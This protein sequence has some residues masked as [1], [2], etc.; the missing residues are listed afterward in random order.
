MV[1]SCPILPEV[2]DDHATRIGAGLVTAALEAFLGYCLG[3]K[4]YTLLQPILS[5][6][7][8]SVAKAGVTVR[9]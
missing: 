5:R 1:E 6:P 7:S 4:V 8:A 2:V 9:S 3:C